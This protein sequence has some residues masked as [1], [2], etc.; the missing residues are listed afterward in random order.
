MD[1]VEIA[2]RTAAQIHRKPTA[3]EM[4]ARWWQ[5][6]YNLPSN[7]ELF[8]KE[9]LFYWLVEYFLDYF[10]K[11][12]LETYRTADGEIQFTD[13][14]DS[15]IDKWEEI[16]AEGG[17]PDL[18]EAFN[19]EALEA[20]KNRKNKKQKNVTVATIGD[21]QKRIEKEL[22]ELHQDPTTGRYQ[23]TRTFG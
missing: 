11:N 17:E 2:K 4:I 12:P 13:T 9:T 15:L 3:E 5:R 18:T 7:H 19:P 21:V 22:R 6:K 1:Q 23:K 20:I 8:Q 14:G 10:E 16:I